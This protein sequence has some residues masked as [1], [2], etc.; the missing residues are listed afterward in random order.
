MRPCLFCRCQ[1]MS[2]QNK[3]LDWKG[4]TTAGKK[5]QADQTVAS[6]KMRKRVLQ[7]RLTHRM[8]LTRNRSQLLSSYLSPDILD[9]TLYIT[10]LTPQTFPNEHSSH[11]IHHGLWFLYLQQ[12]ETVKD[13]PNTPLSGSL[14]QAYAFGIFLESQ[15][16]RNTCEHGVWPVPCIIVEQCY[17]L[18]YCRP[19][20]RPNHQVRHCLCRKII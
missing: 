18:N 6:R 15:R 20:W 11:G 4:H 8:C 7:M 12:V 10:F 17:E 9:S 13:F 14:S 2:K 5:K 1:K 16:Y 3:T 19:A